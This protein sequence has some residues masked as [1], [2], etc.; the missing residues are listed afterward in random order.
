MTASTLVS[1]EDYP[2]IEETQVLRFT[3]GDILVVHVCVGNM[4]PQR[5]EEYMK[6]CKD[7][8]RPMIPEHVQILILPKGDRGVELSKLT[9]DNGTAN[10]DSKPLT[11]RTRFGKVWA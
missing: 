2:K 9:F 8:L 3:K 11:P 4:P 5:A 6:R 7:I 1:S 10:V